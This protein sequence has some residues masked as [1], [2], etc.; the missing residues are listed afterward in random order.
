MV[1]NDSPYTPHDHESVGFSLKSQNPNGWPFCI[2]LDY[3]FSE[4]CKENSQTQMEIRLL[5]GFYEEERD[6]GKEFIR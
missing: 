6:G 5:V 4:F 2:E 3:S 1:K